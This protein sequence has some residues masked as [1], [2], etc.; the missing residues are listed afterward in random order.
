[1]QASI[2]WQAFK[3]KAVYAALLTLAVSAPA[4]GQEF[5]RSFGSFES[6]ERPPTL[7]NLDSQHPTSPVPSTTS[8]ERPRV[9]EMPRL[10]YPQ[11]PTGQRLPPVLIRPVMMPPRVRVPPQHDPQHTP[12]VVGPTVPPVVETVSLSGPRFGYTSLSDGVVRKLNEERHIDIGSLITQFG[13]QFEKQFYSNGEGLTIL[14]EW[15][16]L[17]GGL[18]QSVALPSLSWLVGFRTKEG[19]EFGLGPNVTPAGV[20]LAVAGGVTFRVGAVNIPL[21]VAVVPSK[22]GVRVSMLTGFSL[23]TH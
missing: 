10:Q 18:E 12:A 3:A 23:R 7:E 13:W 8:D 15:V 22:A 16:A 20:A 5:S 21:N 1:M 17:I 11:A 2:R 19:A 4:V 6:S 9:V 14:N